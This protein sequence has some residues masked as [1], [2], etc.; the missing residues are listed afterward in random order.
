MKIKK[1]FI[2]CIALLFCKKTNNT[3]FSITQSPT[4]EDWMGMYVGGSKI[5]YV[6]TK[7]EKSDTGW[8]FR[9]KTRMKIF[10][11]GREEKFSSNFDAFTDSTF[12]LKGFE[13]DLVSRQHTFHA[14][15][16]RLNNK[17]V[18]EIETVDRKF[19][20]EW[21]LRNKLLP[22]PAIGLYLL[23]NK[24]I[25][26][27][28][29]LSVFEPTTLSVVDAEIE[30]LG[31]E[32]IKIKD[33]IYK[34]LHFI[35]KMLGMESSVWIDSTGLSI[36]ELQEP[37]ITM[38]R[39]TREEALKIESEI[40][41]LDLL[42]Y[43]S[44]RTDSTIEHPREIKYLKVKIV[45]IDSIGELKFKNDFQ[46][47]RFKKDTMIIT[48]KKPEIENIKNT[49]A[50]I[51]RFL[52]PSLYIQSNDP[53]I[54]TKAK[55]ITKGT[56]GPKERVEKIVNWMFKNI[57]KRATA[58]IPSAVEV[59]ETMEGDCNEH[60]ILFAALSRAIGIPAKIVVGVVYLQNGFYYHAWNSVYIGGKWIPV[61]AT[62]G[63]FPAD[64]T[65]IQFNEGELTEQAKVLRIV[66]KIKIKV[67][68]YH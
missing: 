52:S 63:E 53:K 54:I 43:F 38:L 22:T 12:E 1:L 66:G 42:S 10:L 64:P 31:W 30:V 13:F 44:I 68:E 4:I 46:K 21:P 61:D 55:E 2:F 35:T 8:T 51:K 36:K 65:H 60:A 11:M 45:G 41:K 3:S 58:S 18:M 59:L 33:H 62:F 16:K 49:T 47:F 28:I 6:Y 48:I 9:Q 40:A 20:K 39:E 50:F 15:G 26:G 37:K 19:K 57:K 29:K 23:A 67:V 7:V 25:K 56:K 17:L 5:G 32:S 24:K 14:R 27:K 34:A